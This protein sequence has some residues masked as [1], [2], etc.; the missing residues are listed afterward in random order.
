MGSTG[1]TAGGSGAAPA[2]GTTGG[3]GAP[4]AMPPRIEVMIAISPGS[5]IPMTASGR[6]SGP[7]TDPAPPAPGTGESMISLPPAA[8]GALDVTWR[9]QR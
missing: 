2:G 1:G 4:P 9:R 8:G 7:G 3:L 6:F 5:T